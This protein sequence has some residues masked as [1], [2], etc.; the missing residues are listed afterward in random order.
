MKLGRLTMYKKIMA[1]F[2]SWFYQDGT[3][4]RIGE[5]IELFPE[6]NIAVVSV[7]EFPL[8]R[9]PCFIWA[10]AKSYLSLWDG[11]DEFQRGLRIVRDGGQYISPKVQKLID[12]RDEW[13]DTRSKMNRR[14]VQR[15]HDRMPCHD[16][17]RDY[18][19]PNWGNTE[20]IQKNG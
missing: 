1:F 14:Q 8:S 9:A 11:N 16:V 17:L 12:H 2:G 20:Y 3:S 6:L 4:C 13:L 15:G 5:L 10:R 19:S 18:L 7:H